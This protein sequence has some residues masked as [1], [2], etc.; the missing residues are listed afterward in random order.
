MCK[1]AHFKIFKIEDIRREDMYRQYLA[2]LAQ[3]KT[4]PGAKKAA[5]PAGYSD[6]RR[7]KPDKP[8]D[9]MP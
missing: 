3:N 2:G 8:A 7:D 6:Y 9:L 1:T 5:S 4:T